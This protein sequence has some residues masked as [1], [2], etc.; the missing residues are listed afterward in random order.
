M[1]K[2]RNLPKVFPGSSDF[3]LSH[4]AAMAL[5]VGHLERR[6]DENAECAGKT[7][8]IISLVRQCYCCSLASFDPLIAPSFGSYNKFTIVVQFSPQF[9]LSSNLTKRTS[10]IQNVKHHIQTSRCQKV[11]RLTN[12]NIQTTHTPCSCAHDN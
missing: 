4:H 5:E 10:H 7:V 12:P 3:P 1:M 8:G 9:H 2:T 11:H 6:L